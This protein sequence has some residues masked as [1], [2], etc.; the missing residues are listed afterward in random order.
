VEIRR[1]EEADLAV[2]ADIFNEAYAEVHRRS[3]STRKTTTT[4][5]GSSRRCSTSSRRTRTAD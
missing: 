4:T 1:I 3:A 5:A 2:C